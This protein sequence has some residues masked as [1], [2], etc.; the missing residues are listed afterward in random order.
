MCDVDKFGKF[1]KFGS[2]HIVCGVDKFG[3]FGSLHIVCDEDKFGSLE[4][5][6][7][8]KLKWTDK[9]GS[10]EVCISFAESKRQ[11]TANGKRS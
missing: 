5:W 6:K 7:F 11:L 9:F 2:L 3:K 1:G 8:T 10:L 4:V